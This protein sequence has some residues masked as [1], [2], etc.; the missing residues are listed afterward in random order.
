VSLN[1]ATSLVNG[2]FPRQIVGLTAL[3]SALRKQTG[4]QILA[5]A[6]HSTAFD[7]MLRE[8]SACPRIQLVFITT[9]FASADAIRNLFQSPT[10]TRLRLSA[11]PDL[12]L[13]VADEIRQGSMPLETAVA[14]DVPTCSF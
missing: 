12:W 2:S 7:P 4:L 6:A 13:A 14:L 11:K 9:K 3:A 1:G 10:D 8:L 5:E